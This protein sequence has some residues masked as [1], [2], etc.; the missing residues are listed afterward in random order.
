MVVMDLK[1]EM[2]SCRAPCRAHPGDD[3]PGEDVLAG[4]NQTLGVVAVQRIERPSVIQNN[5]F[6]ISAVFTAIYNVTG[7][8]R[9]HGRTALGG[10]I[11]TRMEARRAVDRVHPPAEGG[12]NRAVKRRLR[13]VCRKSA[14]DRRGQ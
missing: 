2:R 10:N 1:M 8:G 7:L 9:Q 12:G 6:A 5:H 13:S 4:L 3:L 14:Q 11:H